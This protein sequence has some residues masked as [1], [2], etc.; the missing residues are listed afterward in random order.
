MS[1]RRPSA[2]CLPLGDVALEGLD[3]LVRPAEPPLQ[4]DEAGV[5]R[6]EHAFEFRPIL[7]R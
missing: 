4:I 1:L 7:P 6:L 5:A 3:G 2:W